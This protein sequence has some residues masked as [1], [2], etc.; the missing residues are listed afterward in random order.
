KEKYG[1]EML[2]IDDV[3]EAD[4]LEAQAVSLHVKREHPESWDEFDSA[5]FEALWV[6]GR[7]IGDVDVLADIGD[8]VGIS[9]EEVR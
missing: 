6:D 3:P 8:D 1:V 5:V 4:S 9:P 7:D 2:G